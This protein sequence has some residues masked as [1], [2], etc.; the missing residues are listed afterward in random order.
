MPVFPYFFVSS[1]NPDILNS[2]QVIRFK[3]NG[4]LLSMTINISK[5][6]QCV[7]IAYCQKAD[8]LEIIC[9]DV[10][11]WVLYN[12]LYLGWSMLQSIKERRVRNNTASFSDRELLS[13]DTKISEP[14]KIKLKKLI[15][16]CE[17][18]L[19]CIDGYLWKPTPLLC[20]FSTQILPLCMEKATHPAL[21]S[22]E[23]T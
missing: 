12:S 14:Q 13:W 18:Q 21:P 5:W 23:P 15:C 7:L 19:Y 4:S 11:Y 17:K 22:L 9:I 3:F 10:C 16:I 8:H 20:C 2:V 1:N 6:E